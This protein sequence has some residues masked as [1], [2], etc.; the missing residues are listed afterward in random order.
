MS[1]SLAVSPEEFMPA[2]GLPAELPLI[3]ED[4]LVS[5]L[6]QGAESELDGLVACLLQGGITCQ[7]K[8]LTVYKANQPHHRVYVNDIAAELQKFGANTIASAFRSG[9]GVAYREIVQ[10][11]ADRLG[12]S[13]EGTT[14]DIEKCI[15]QKLAE[16]FWEGATAEQ[17]LALLNQVGVRDYSL[18]A[19]PAL[20]AAVI[21]AVHLSGFAAYQFTVI[22]A[23]A[24]AHAVLGR[25][26][27]LAANAGLT[28]G[29]SIFAGPPGWCLVAFLTAHSI[30][31][32]AYRV[33]IPAVVQVALIRSAIEARR[34]QDAERTRR[35][36]P[37]NPK[38]LAVALVLLCAAV[39]AA[40]MLLVR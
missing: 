1:F 40:I 37:V 26:L 15:L 3:A 2:V 13:R 28:K 11:V 4:E 38:L 35:K 17:R 8:R 36:L 25:G 30:A 12:I 20:P 16:K 18:V 19:R 29:V 27:S 23:N 22:V 32:E 5:I 33:T 14:M 31:S 6:Q 9:K 10:D 24:I 39:I 7:L 21:S 34:E